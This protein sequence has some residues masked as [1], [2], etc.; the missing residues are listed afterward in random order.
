MSMKYN[1]VKPEKCIRQKTPKTRRKRD[2]R[3]FERSARGQPAGKISR[4]DHALDLDSLLLPTDDPA[5]Q[6]LGSLAPGSRRSQWSAIRRVALI[7]SDGAITDG[8][9]P[10][11][12]L[13]PEDVNHVRQVLIGTVAPPTGRRYL[14]VLKAV[15]EFSYI[16]GEISDAKRARL[17]H[18][19][20]LRPIR[21]TSPP[22]GRALDPSEAARFLKSCEADRMPAARR[23]AAIFGL[24]YLAGLRGRE[25]I[26]L[27]LDDL[28]LNTGLLKIH[29]KGAKNRAVILSWD[30][31]R[32]VW[33]W[34]VEVRGDGGD[35]CFVH[36]ND[37]G[38]LSTLAGSLTASYSR[39]FAAG[40]RGAGSIHSRPT[41]SE[42]AL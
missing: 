39:T 23:D 27:D 18:P 8:L 35:P 3:I 1:V 17:I 34:V 29:G 32:L 7:L 37:G 41:T 36:S 15:I 2:R 21:G 38:G 24:M 10:W 11:S 31:Q 25:V 40:P 4:T 13:T 26:N 33:R 42:E 22:A 16:K 28:D 12:E 20:N 9:Y 6:Y 30:A 5:R 19:R 14:G